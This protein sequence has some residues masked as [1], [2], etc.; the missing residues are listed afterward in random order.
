M[1]S[2]MDERSRALK[3]AP[4]K[5]FDEKADEWDEDNPVELLMRTPNPF[6]TQADL[7]ETIE[8]HLSLTGNAFIR[9]VRDQK[10][11]VKQ[12]WIMQPH[13]VNIVPSATKF[14]SGYIYKVDGQEYPLPVEDV[15]H[16]L[17]IDP[18]DDYYGIAPL[19]A[20][21]RRIDADSELAK[22]TKQLLLN[23]AVTSGCFVTEKKLNP[24]ERAIMEE[25]MASRYVGAVRAGLPMVLSHGMKWEQTSMTM[26]DLEIGNIASIL[27][28]RI[29]LALH[30]PAIVVGAKVGLDRSTFTNVRE[31]REYMYE[32]T[33]S[34]EWQMIAD[35]LG[36]ALLIDFGHTEGN[37]IAR[38]DT[39]KIKALQES[40]QALWE[41]VRESKCL[42]IIEK[43]LLLGYK[44]E[45]NGAIFLD[46]NMVAINPETG[47]MQPRV[48]E[49]EAGVKKEQNLKD[50]GK[51]EKD[52]KGLTNDPP[53]KTKEE[54]D[55]SSMSLS[56]SG[57]KKLK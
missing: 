31:A 3:E 36:G 55:E 30:V 14:I 39:S 24:E 42:S 53:K 41:R 32:N 34:P 33:I 50:G 20:A 29:C 49:I 11:V 43:R 12:L 9:K 28:S 48:A 35:K 56:K 52:D 13:L 37:L 38:F 15:I 54:E 1:H 26:K 40:E 5:V 19:V 10:G 17:Y 21:A 25:K 46:A 8:Q 27:E 47:E 7:L 22:F 18:A 23:M 51:T 57:K 6:R 16:L 2:C 4:L 44:A 45:S